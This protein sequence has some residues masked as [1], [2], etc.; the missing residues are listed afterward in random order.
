MARCECAA[1]NKPFVS[2]DSF[3]HHRVGRHGIYEGATRRRCLNLEEMSAAGWERSEKGW[4]H[5]KGMRNLAHKA[6]ARGRQAA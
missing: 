2:V 5:P 3:D 1:C 4:R 6:Q